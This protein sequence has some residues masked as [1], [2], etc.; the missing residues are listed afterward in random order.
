VKPY[1]Q[2]GQVLA[3]V[4]VFLPAI[5]AG[6][7]LV[8]D[9]ALVFKARREALALADAAAQYGAAQIDQAAK[10]ANPTAPA[11]LDVPKAES[12]ARDYV[13][14]H[15]PDALVQTSATRQRVEVDVTLQAPTII[16]HLPSESNVAIQAH[17]NAQPFTGVATGQAP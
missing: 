2:R 16:W 7:A 8:V 3:L 13:L 10:R 9:T 4:A 6:L 11:P 12:M 14:I 17:G 5:I 1:R 15:R